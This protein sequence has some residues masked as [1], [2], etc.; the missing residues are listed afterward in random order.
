MSLPHEMR[1]EGVDN[2]SRRGVPGAAGLAATTPCIAEETVPVGVWVIVPAYNEA[3]RMG[4]V[5][6]MLVGF[7]QDIVVVDDG[8]WDGTA[9]EALRRLVWVPGT[10][11]ISG[12]ARRCRPGSLL[13][14]IRG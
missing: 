3:A 1:S 9:A 7:V 8:S 12:R 5:L 14:S 6:D 4:Q 13:R 2:Q 10:P 11:S